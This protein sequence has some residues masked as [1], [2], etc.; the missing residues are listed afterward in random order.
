MELRKLGIFSY[1]ETSMKL[2][3][4]MTCMILKNLQEVKILKPFFISK[5]ISCFHNAYA[6][7]MRISSFIMF[8]SMKIY[9]WLLILSYVS[10]IWIILKLM[11]TKH[12]NMNGAWYP[13]VS[14]EF[15][16]YRLSVCLMVPVTSRGIE[17][18][19]DKGLLLSDL[20]LVHTFIPSLLN[21]IEKHYDYWLYIG[22][23]ID[24][25]WY[26]NETNWRTLMNFIQIKSRETTHAKLRLN[27]RP[28]KLYGI[29]KRITAI[30]NSLAATAYRDLCDYFYPANDDL[31]FQTEGWTSSAIRRLKKCTFASNFGIVAF[32]DIAACDYPTFHLT[33]RTH[34]DL[35]DGIYYP[36]PFHGAHQD[37]WIFSVYRPWKCAF[38]LHHLKVKNHIGLEG[39]KARYEYGDSQRLVFWVQLSRQRL[40]KRLSSLSSFH[41]DQSFINLSRLT[42]DV[43]LKIP[44]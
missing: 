7:K 22:Y 18:N 20:P 10:F 42:T 14:N 43:E 12:T 27:V 44:C 39:G 15:P 40:Y 9:V 34:L 32:K 30:W 23:D 21:T 25:P 31:Q 26:D 11:K 1:K 19:K 33:H 36:L 5:N 13:N 4:E 16:P 35:H 8:R 3:I 29:D 24:D 37:P 41:Y 6:F 28:V 2:L 38:V 17:Y